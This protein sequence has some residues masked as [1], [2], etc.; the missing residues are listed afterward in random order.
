MTRDFEFRL[1]I[2]G[3]EASWEFTIPE[4]RSI[5]GRQAGNDLLLENPQISRQHA[6][7][8]CTPAECQI[9]DLG[10]ANGT[11]LNDE[12]LTPKI[13]VTLNP[14]D[15]IKIGPFTLEVDHSPVEKPQPKV[16]PPTRE[17]PGESGPIEVVLGEAPFPLATPEAEPPSKPVR[18][19][20]A[21]PPPPELPPPP[22]GTVPN[23]GSLILPGLSIHSTRLL[24]YLPDI[25]HTDF[26]SRFL[27]IFEAILTPI[28]WN[29]NNFDL[30]LSAGTAPVDF[31]V[32]L[33]N[34]F[35]ITS[36]T[37]WSESQRRQLLAEAH[38][39]YA[40]RGTRWALSRILEIYTG[41]AP[42]I[43]DQ[44][45]KLAAYTF[46]VKL[47]LSKKK[48]NQELIEA[49]I[50]ANKPAHTTYELKFERS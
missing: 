16:Q 5:M 46:S 34:W 24:N 26:M 33:A 6:Q 47:P 18:Q 32:W 1:H 13:P 25:Y 4:G 37:T 28:E 44:D 41:T 22:R 39:I 36:D 35:E 38:R 42:E 45:D 7:F 20:A 23:D 11:R 12:K 8:D 21:P 10:S 3:P 48:V 14:K 17:L 27:A 43:V 50:D 15:I 40:R 31:L 29:T 49:I 2:Q 9:T 19:K 30:Y